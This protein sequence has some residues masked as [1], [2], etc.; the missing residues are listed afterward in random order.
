MPL[1][2]AQAENFVVEFFRDHRLPAPAVAT[3][4]RFTVTLRRRKR[5]NLPRVITRET[6]ADQMAAQLCRGC[7][8]RMR[9]KDGQKRP[10]I[11]MH[12]PEWRK[13]VRG[14]VVHHFGKGDGLK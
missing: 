10:R 8:R 2:R 14:V 1:T 5:L 11:A 4:K 3:R 6:L 13:Y 9:M 12:F 7:V